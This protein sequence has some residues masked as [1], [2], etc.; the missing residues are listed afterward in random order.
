MPNHWPDPSW[1]DRFLLENPWPA[2][3]VFAAFALIFVWHYLRQRRRA[4]LIPALGCAVVAGVVPLLAFLVTTPRERLMPL[5]EQFVHAVVPKLPGADIATLEKLLSPAIDFQISSPA[6]S[7]SHDRK[8]LLEQIDRVLRKYHPH[9]AILLDNDAR[10]LSTGQYE[11][12]FRVRVTFDA[13]NE[14]PLSASNLSATTDWLLQWS[15]QPDGS[16]RIATLRW[17]KINGIDP[18]AS[19]LP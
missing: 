2:L 5:D 8:A 9:D 7:Q 15:G 16:F 19:L 1:F 3:A 12:Y 14:G 13:A 17:L 4:L 6:V 11:S 18:A 10:Q